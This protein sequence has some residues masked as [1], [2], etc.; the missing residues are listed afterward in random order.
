MRTQSQ[1]T[2]R[3]GEPSASRAYSDR[4]MR[5]VVRG[6][7]DKRGGPVCP[8]PTPAYTRRIPHHPRQRSRV[9][10]PVCPYNILKVQI[11]SVR[12]VYTKLA[13]PYT[14]HPRVFG[15]GGGLG[16]YI[17]VRSAIYIFR[18][19]ATLV[20]G[21]YRGRHVR[22]R[23]WVPALQSLSYGHICHE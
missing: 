10:G 21:W 22:R 8:H 18:I 11:S 3:V 7:R 19:P 5:P 16:S 6:L 14:R 20:R 17:L 15:H 4:E 1:P 2:T 23:S 13:L 12:S 9:W